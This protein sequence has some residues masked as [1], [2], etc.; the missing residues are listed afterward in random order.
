MTLDEDK[1]RE[2]VRG[3]LQSVLEDTDTYKD[4]Q[5]LV[6]DDVFGVDREL[7]GKE[8]EAEATKMFDTIMKEY[9]DKIVK[10]FR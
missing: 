2:S 8:E 10:L 3:Y 6:W 5:E 7:D 4:V 9:I 1:M